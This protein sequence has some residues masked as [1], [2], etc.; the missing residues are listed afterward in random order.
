M[1]ILSSRVLLT[2]SDLAASTAF[3]RDILGLAVYRE[4]GVGGIVFF[5]GGG[6]LELAGQGTPP[7]P[8]AFRL[9]LQVRDVR[10]THAAL[11]ARGVPVDGPPELKPWALWEM[12]ARDPDGLELVFVEVPAD[13]PLRRDPRGP[14]L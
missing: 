12:S 5:L 7:P 14:A 11:E 1:D 2:P 4:F 9:W 13:H 10:A 3:Y 6:F 8:G